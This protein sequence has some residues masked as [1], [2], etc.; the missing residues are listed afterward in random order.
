MN[1]EINARAIMSLI[2]KTNKHLKELRELFTIV[3]L[4]L[5]ELNKL[6]KKLNYI[7]GT[8][9]GVTEK[10]ITEELKFLKEYISKCSDE[11]P[12]ITKILYLPKPNK[13]GDKQ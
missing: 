13:E 12:N 10:E 3:A 7:S 5:I 2:T 11:V 6:I 1:E 8:D 9:S 4:Q